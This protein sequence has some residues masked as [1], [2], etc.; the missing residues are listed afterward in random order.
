MLRNPQR[1]TI[2]VATSSVHIV[3]LLHLYVIGAWR[4]RHLGTDGDIH[5]AIRNGAHLRNTISG[6]INQGIGGR[7]IET[8]LIRTQTET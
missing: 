6:A 3:L 5:F 7:L 8:H 4:R 2:R 1:V